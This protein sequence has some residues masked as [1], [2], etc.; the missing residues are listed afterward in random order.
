M[1]RSSESFR[2][3][4]L[5][6]LIAAEARRVEPLGHLDGPSQMEKKGRWQERAPFPNNTNNPLTSKKVLFYDVLNLSLHGYLL[7]TGQES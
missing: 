3:C 5:T 4:H 1:Y 6:F 7:T 2:V